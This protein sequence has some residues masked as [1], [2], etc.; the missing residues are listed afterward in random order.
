MRVYKAGRLAR[1]I[2]VSTGSGRRFCV[3]GKCQTAH[4]PRGSYRIFARRGGWHTSYLGRLYNP[5][6]FSGGYA[7]HGAGSVPSYPASHG[8]VRVSV[9]T[10]SWL[11]SAIPNGTPVRVHD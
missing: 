4:T 2:H 11:A 7:I 1:T 8:C 10:A 3:G 9:G 5:L 6:Y